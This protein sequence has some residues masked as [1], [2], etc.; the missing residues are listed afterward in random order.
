[1]DRTVP[2]RLTGLP[3]RAIGVEVVEGPDFGRRLRAEG[4][5][6]T[7]GT[8][9][10]NDLVLSDETVSRFHLELRR[11]DNGVLLLDHGSTNGVE[12]GGVAI[13]SGTAR[14]GAVLRC[15][16]TRLRVDDAAIVRVDAL[17]ADHF[18][19]LWG[20][21]PAMRRLFADLD[22]AAAILAPVLLIGETGTGKEVIARTL[23]EASPRADG[24]FEIVDCGTLQPTL[25]ADELFGH[26]RG[27]FT[28]ALSAHAGAFE[29]AS[30]GTLFLDEI[31]ELPPAL[32]PALLGAL[33][34]KAIRPV[35]GSEMKPVDV[36]IVAA[37][38]RDLRASVNSGDFRQDLFY[39]LAVVTCRVPPL[40][41][42]ADDIPLLLERF[43]AEAGREGAT[44]EI[45]DPA[46]LEAL[47]RHSWPGNVRELRNFVESTLAL[48]RTP[49][50]SGGAPEV[51]DPAPDL[52]AAIA[53]LLEQPYHRA[54][55]ALVECFER[56]YVARLLERAG[57]NH[58]K[59]AR[60]AGVNRSYLR[61]LLQR[62]YPSER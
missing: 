31:G 20:R 18:G 54:R 43:M 37:T 33:E 60:I 10:G 58:S 50:L 56:A 3:V 36:R 21:S 27:A 44:A 52:G 1:M 45:L 32:Q 49:E 29:R 16:R 42:R 62:H 53:P 39:R 34:R 55:A 9:P 19:A 23:H 22:R 57:P 2:H 15:G 30:G 12:V 4:E 48:G 8:A 59:A 14:A 41:E 24:P 7:V 38:N 13:H 40:R 6:V 47:E 35:G 11:S 28:G 17:E 5:T 26:E 25:I 61:D 51:R 46:M